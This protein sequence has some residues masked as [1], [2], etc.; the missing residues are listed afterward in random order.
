MPEEMAALTA[1]LREHTQQ[2]NTR[3]ASLEEGVLN[4][5][6]DTNTVLGE[7]GNLTGGDFQRWAIA[8]SERIARRDFGLRDT[9]LVHHAGLTAPSELRTALNRAAENQELAFGEAEAME[10]ELADA[11]V[12]GH[13][14]TGSDA[15]LLTEISVTVEQDDVQ[16]A[17]ERAALLTQ[18]TGIPSAAAVIGTAITHAAAQQTAT[19]NV[20]FV[21]LRLRRRR[22]VMPMVVVPLLPSDGII[23]SRYEQVPTLPI[24]PKST[25]SGSAPYPKSLPPYRFICLRHS[26]SL[27]LDF[28]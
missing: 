21:E 15:Y 18:A 26:P 7:M 14:D 17:A 28:S 12:S 13:D 24:S 1:A 22:T 5:R 9:G 3:L 6:R 2:T 8:I 20:R 4:L 19:R 10:V 27:D 25:A 16:R 23:H 11:I